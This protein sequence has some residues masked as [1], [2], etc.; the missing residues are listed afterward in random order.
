MKTEWE[1]SCEG[2]R[3]HVRPHTVADIVDSVAMVYRMTGMSRFGA[4]KRS[5][6]VVS[7]MSDERSLVVRKIQ[8]GN[9]CHRN[10]QDSLPERVGQK[11]MEKA[12]MW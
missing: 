4:S 3:Y 5:V 6:I 1:G 10:N 2:V 9:I 11:N 7:L 8:T 12:G